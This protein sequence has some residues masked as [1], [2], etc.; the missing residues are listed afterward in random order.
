MEHSPEQAYIT[1]KFRAQQKFIENLYT[2]KWKRQLS[3]GQKPKWLS[4]KHYDLY[5]SLQSSNIQQS[6]RAILL[7]I[8][9]GTDTGLEPD[10]IQFLNKVQEKLLSYKNFIPT[11]Y[12]SAIEILTK[13]GEPTHPHIHIAFP[14]VNAHSKTQYINRAYNALTQVSKAYPASQYQ[15]S[16]SKQSIDV[17]NTADY[18][19]YKDYVLKNTHSAPCD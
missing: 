8:S 4:N 18:N 19:T 2:K 11:E 5:K 16:F 12:T 14:N 10:T 13:K 15:P 9:P 6:D 1:G 7:T 17:V 3:N